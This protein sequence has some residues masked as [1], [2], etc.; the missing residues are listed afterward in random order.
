MR[1]VASQRNRAFTLIELLVVVAVIA[2][3]IGLL[4][5][6]LGSA[7]VGAQNVQCLSNLKQFAV[8]QFSYAADYDER[9]TP[10]EDRLAM[11]EPDRGHTRF[12]MNVLMQ[13]NY[14]PAPAESS[15]SVYSCPL[16]NSVAGPDEGTEFPF[17]FAGID[18]EQEEA[19]AWYFEVEGTERRGGEQGDMYRVSYA[20]NA[21]YS[22]QDLPGAARFFGREGRR[23]GSARLGNF[24]PSTFANDGAVD[25][26][27]S[28]LSQPERDTRSVRL[29]ATQRPVQVP[30]VFDGLLLLGN[31]NLT[32]G[33]DST[34]WRVLPRHKNDT[35]NLVF[36][37][38]HA[39]SVIEERVNATPEFF[40]NSPDNILNADG[41]FDV[42]WAARAP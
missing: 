41:E 6:A 42:K 11:I 27:G 23:N 5:P 19:A 31:G 1:H 18:V 3:L 15:N 22:R 38:G 7:R 2:L 9:F 29:S 25:R 32:T 36:I 14:L 28:R 17:N 33:S 39:G 35:T 24:F 16:A 40:S 26:N 20:I 34:E 10:V 13:K 8:A 30:I 4:L 12:W 37:D 21:P